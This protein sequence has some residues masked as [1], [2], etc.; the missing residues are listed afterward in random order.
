MKW[1]K[2]T[3]QVWVSERE[4]DQ[5]R[6]RIVEYDGKYHGYGENNG[7]T[8]SEAFDTLKEAKRWV[9]D[10]TGWNPMDTDNEL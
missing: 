5:C 10:N 9:R 8:V 3:D 7:N 4:A 2:L 1:F 6:S